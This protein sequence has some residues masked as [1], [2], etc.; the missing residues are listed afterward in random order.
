MSAQPGADERATAS[1]GRVG[2][3]ESADVRR[4]GEDEW[5]IVAWLWQCFR[6]DLAL[7]VSG[8]PYADGRYQKSGSLLSLHPLLTTPRGLRAGAGR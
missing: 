1:S 2:R 8:L 5:Q 3:V 4:V 6:H 7:V